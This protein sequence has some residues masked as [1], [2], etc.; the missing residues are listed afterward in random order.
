LIDGFTL[1][2]QNTQGPK[3]WAR[4]AEGRNVRAGGAAPH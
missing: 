1:R 4:L 3:E 2:S